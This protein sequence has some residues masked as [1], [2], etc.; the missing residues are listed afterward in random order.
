MNIVTRTGANAF[1]GTAFEFLRNN[2]FN[3]QNY[4]WTKGTLPDTLKRNQFGGVG[5]VD[6]S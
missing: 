2:F 1:H 5:L 4:F 3:A 6:R